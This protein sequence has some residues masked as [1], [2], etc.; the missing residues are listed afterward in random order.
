VLFLKHHGSS[1]V[2]LKSTVGSAASFTVRET[3]REGPILVAYKSPL[4][5]RQITPR[6]GQET[7]F[8]SGPSLTPGEQIA[9]L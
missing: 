5:G 1:Q 2:S 3:D 7:P 4:D 8:I 6:R 9:G